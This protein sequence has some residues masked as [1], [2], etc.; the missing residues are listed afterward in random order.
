MAVESL[1]QARTQIALLLACW[2]CF[3]ALE[4]RCPTLLHAG[5]CSHLSDL[6]DT[7]GSSTPTPVLP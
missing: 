5:P 6:H 4:V 1:H 2:S 3:V 7:T